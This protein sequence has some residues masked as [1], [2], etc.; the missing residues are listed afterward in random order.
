MYIAEWNRNHVERGQAP[1]H[2]NNSR[3]N[4]KWSTAR[5]PVFL[6]KKLNRAMNAHHHKAHSKFGRVGDKNLRNW[7]I[8]QD[9]RPDAHK[10]SFAVLKLDL[11]R[12]HK[13]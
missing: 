13:H 4:R 1:K 5:G 3:L 9:S 10:K 12:I 7:K 11:L 8:M 6:S 2:N